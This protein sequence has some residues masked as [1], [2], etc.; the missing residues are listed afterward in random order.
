MPPGETKQSFL[1]DAALVVTS[2]ALWSS[3]WIA[4]KY[5]MA[6]TH[7]AP[8]I[9]LL[10]LPAGFRLLIVIVFGVWGALGIFLADPLMFMLEFEQ[11]SLR[12]VVINALISGFAPYLTVLA[13]CRLAG[14]RGSLTQLKPLHLP[15]LALAVSFVTPLLFNLHYLAEGRTPPQAFLHNFTAMMTGDFL[16][17]LV[18]SILARVALAVGRAAFPGAR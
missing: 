2:A 6:G 15:L 12:E 18:V 11:G 10:F 17:C 9:D 7:V 16:G 4:N 13:F 8:G 14:I 3:I 1:L 5:L